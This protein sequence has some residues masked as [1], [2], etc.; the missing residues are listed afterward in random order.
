MYKQ[1]I[2]AVQQYFTW[3]CFIFLAKKFQ[4]QNWNARNYFLI[5]SSG[6]GSQSSQY[7]F[8]LL[9]ALFRCFSVIPDS[10]FPEKHL[11]RALK[12]WN[13]YRELWDLK[14]ELKIKRRLH[15]S[16][17]EGKYSTMKKSTSAKMFKL[18]KEN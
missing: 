12:S 3:L 5:F 9:R 10:V 7:M 15:K 4:F 11:K 17:Q 13:M 16:F 6:F 8:R 18:S 2:Y 1:Y 14:P